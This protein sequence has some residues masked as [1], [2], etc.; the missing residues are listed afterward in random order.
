MTSRRTDIVDAVKGKVIKISV[1]NGF[2][3]E[4]SQQYFAHVMD[5]PVTLLPNQAV[6]IHQTSHGSPMV[7]ALIGGMLR[8]HREKPPWDYYVRKL[9]E[10][11]RSVLSMTSNRNDYQHESIDEAIRLSVES[12]KDDL[13][14]KFFD[15]AVFDDGT[16][17]EVSPTFNLV[18]YKFIVD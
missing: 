16:F 7:M 3:Q 10:S 5:C 14:E 9:E 1:D 8:E 15:F 17:I 4:E 13:R 12:L 2:T 11:P 18:R 6:T